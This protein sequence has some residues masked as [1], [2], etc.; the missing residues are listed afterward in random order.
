MSDSLFK[1]VITPLLTP[2]DQQEKID[3]KSL[4]KLVK[5][6][7]SNSTWSVGLRDIL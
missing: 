6:Q 7:L 3:E 2:I 4:R 5:Y 1:G